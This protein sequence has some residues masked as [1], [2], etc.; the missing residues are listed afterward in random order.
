MKKN[1][2]GLEC[3]VSNARLLTRVL[4]DLLPLRRLKGIQN[5]EIGESEM[6]MRRGW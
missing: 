5:Q 3:K 2:T 4:S 6:E 1:Q